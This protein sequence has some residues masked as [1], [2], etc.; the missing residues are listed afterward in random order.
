MSFKACYRWP[1][2]GRPYSLYNS[3]ENV[4]SGVGVVINQIGTARDGTGMEKGM[5]SAEL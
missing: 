5:A 3:R 4:A 2:P 1:S